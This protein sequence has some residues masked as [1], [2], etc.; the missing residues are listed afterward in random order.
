MPAG[1]QTFYT[2]G[3]LA[4]DITDRTGRFQNTVS[5]AA[6]TSG[7]ITVSKEANENVFAFLLTDGSTTNGGCAVNQSTGVITYSLDG[8]ASG[9]LFH[10]VF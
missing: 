2:D 9:T 5:I 3:S 7:T 8:P 6:N 10:G 1:L 4:L